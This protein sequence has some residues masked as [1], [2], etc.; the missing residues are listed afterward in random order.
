MEEEAKETADKGDG[1]REAWRMG[2]GRWKKKESKGS[3]KCFG[4]IARL[5]LDRT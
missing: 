2:R 4:S 3:L 5:N 1:R